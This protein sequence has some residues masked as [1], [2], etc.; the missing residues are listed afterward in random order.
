MMACTRIALFVLATVM[1][2]GAAV[3][4]Q[5]RSSD[6]QSELRREIQALRDGQEALREAL[7]EIKTLIEERELTERT[8]RAVTVNVAEA[9][10]RGDPNAP[11]TLVEFSDFRLPVLRCAG[12]QARYWEMYA[13][14][15]AHQD[16]QSPDDLV[17]HTEDLDL[18]LDAFLEC[19]D[20]EKHAGEAVRLPP[21][22]IRALTGPTSP[23]LPRRLRRRFFFFFS[24]SCRRCRR[25]S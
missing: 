9:P 4:A 10:F 11:V 19:L 17:E 6:D 1:L 16:E 18:D 25:T 8:P 24:S 13:V 20:D 12:D 14:L 15:F 5:T 23:R 21:D 3:R 7:A 22:V 2:G